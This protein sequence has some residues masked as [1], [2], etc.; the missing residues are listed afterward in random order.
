MTQP[1]SS[2]IINQKAVLIR[3]DL[4]KRTGPAPSRFI[5]VGS[6]AE[7]IGQEWLFTRDEAIE[8]RD[9]LTKAIVEL[10]T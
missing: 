1:E 6:V 10:A 4:S 7:P 3:L 9:E 5:T 8:L 2:S